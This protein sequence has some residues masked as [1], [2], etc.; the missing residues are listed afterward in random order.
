MS[1]FKNLYQ[2]LDVSPV[3]S[4]EEI[5]KAMC[6]AAESQRIELADL[7]LCQQI[8]LDL[9]ARKKYNTKLFKEYPELLDELIPSS[10]NEKTPENSKKEMPLDEEGVPS[11]IDDKQ[12]NDKQSNFVNSIL[13]IAGI[14]FLVMIVFFLYSSCSNSKA[15]KTGD[16]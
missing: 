5:K 4:V 6:S 7:Q 14:I 3:V 10:K 9:E 2:L 12:H 1:D 15:K 13:G 16:H 8:L 11:K